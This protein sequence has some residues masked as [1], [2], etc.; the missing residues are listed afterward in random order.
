MGIA[1]T[2]QQGSLRVNNWPVI[3]VVG[4]TATGKS[5]LALGL[6]HHLHAVII[7]ADSMQLYKGMDI[8]TA[9]LSLDEREG[10]EHKL[11]DVW[12]VTFTASVAEYQTMARMCIASATMPVLLVGG[13]GLYQRAVLDE[14]EFPGTSPEIRA[15]LEVEL[16]AQGE[17]ALRTRLQGLDPIAAAAIPPGNGRRVVRALEV[18]ELTGQPFSATLP[19]Y[20]KPYYDNVTHI[21][22]ELSN[23]VLDARIEARVDRMLE[24]GLLE[25]VA[26]LAEQ[27]LR[28]G[29]TA[30]KALGYKECLDHLD[31]LTTWDQA[32]ELTIVNTRK[33]ARRQQKWFRR[34]PRIT[35]I[36]ATA[37]AENQQELALH[38]LRLDQ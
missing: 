2:S 8:G 11:L 36:D 15:A 22:L 38:A 10:I 23:D 34:D 31:G 20:D 26:I 5:S 29:V 16:E 4:A 21:G 33:F 27:G 9:K 35:W 25:E 17:L 28:E 1:L 7:N 14:L 18:I 12:P 19:S 24:Q 3:S 13:S 37:T 32:R 30:S 6:A